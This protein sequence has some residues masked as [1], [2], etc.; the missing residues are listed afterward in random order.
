MVEDGLMAECMQNSS[1]SKIRKGSILI[2][3][4][5]ALFNNALRRGLISFGHE[6]TSTFT[7]DEALS[8]LENNA[9]DLVV[10]DL[11]LPDGEGE[12]LLENLN[13]RQKLKII[14]YTSD[15]DKERRNEWF[16]YGVLGYL[17]KN[18][19]FPHVIQEIDKTLKAIQENTY[20]NILVVDDSSVVRRQVTS[21]LQPRNYKINIAIDGGSAIETINTQQLDLILLDL[22]LPDMNGEEVLKYL[23]KNS[24][25]AEIPVFILTGTYDASTVGKLIKQGANEFF[26]KPFIPE[27]LLLKIDFWIDSKR[28]ARERECER[29][30]LQEYKDTVDR[31]S[32]V[33][34]TDKRGIITFVN[35]KF[36]EISGYSPAELIGKPHNTVRHPDMPKEAFEELWQTILSGQVWEGIVKNRKKDGSPYWV[37]TTINPIV[38]IDGNI[39][40]YIGVRTDIT[41]LQ[42]IKERLQDKLHISEENFEDIYRRAQLYE[43]AIDESNILSRT[44]DDGTILYVNNRFC[45][46]TGYREEEIIGKT[47]AIVRHPDTPKKVFADMWKTIQSGRVWNGVLKN[48]KKDGSPYWVDSTIIPIKDKEEKIIEYMAIRHEVTEIITLHEEIEKT[49]QEIIYR[50]GEIGESRSKETGNHVRRVAEYSKLLALKAGLD[51]KEANL[52]ADASPMHD[53]G[54]VAI[55][56][57]VLHKPGSLNDAEWLVMRSHSSIGHKV[58]SGSDRPLLN[59]ASIIAHEHHEKYSGGGYPS[60]LVGEDIHIYARIVTIADVFDALGSDRVY[61]KAWSL[62][63]IINLL[64]EEKGKHFDPRLVELFLDNLDDFLVIRDRYQDHTQF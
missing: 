33:S 49:Q 36:C 40:E 53:I 43:K 18:D 28:K 31:S 41:E 4:D 10:L 51:E 13:S 47:H 26:L 5:S 2:V 48:R 25:T 57:S 39:V 21:L 9:Y 44:T 11:H 15:P 55:P 59:A 37:Q 29:Q 1:A 63:K 38:D 3:E 23:K 42:Q 6:V 17:S 22:E 32:I 19:P 30:L 7:L 27:E 46:I 58:L 14:V 60:G 8:N 61:K 56:D 45:E 16:R 24:A 54:K 62:D 64:K 20:Y 34:K 50:M 52:I 35:D 12:D